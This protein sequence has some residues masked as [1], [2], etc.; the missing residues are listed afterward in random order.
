MP[1]STVY[2]QGRDPERLKLA[3]E[4]DSEWQVTW[5]DVWKATKKELRRREL[6]KKSVR[7]LAVDWFSRIVRDQSDVKAVCKL[8]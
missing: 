2:G 5:E 1:A 7:M 3:K 4:A 8:V 6:L